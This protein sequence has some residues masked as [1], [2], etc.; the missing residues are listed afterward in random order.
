VSTRFST[1]FSA[2]LLQP[3]CDRE[4]VV[5][6]HSDDPGSV[7]QANGITWKKP[8]RCVFA[9]A[10]DG[11]AS[12]MNELQWEI[13]SDLTEKMTLSYFSIWEVTNLTPTGLSFLMSGQL[14]FSS[15]LR[16]ND[17][18][19]VSSGGLRISLPTVG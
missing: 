2:S 18:V 14:Q 6:L 19:T 4:V 1:A 16:A 13:S 17:I 10:L 5:F 12:N 15:P 3:L 7:G 8:A 11:S 9:L